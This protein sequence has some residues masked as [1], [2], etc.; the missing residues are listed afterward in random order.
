MAEV[1]KMKERIIYLRKN[2]LHLSQEEFGSYI[3]LKQGS[4]SA[5]EKGIN[6]VSEY[7]IKNICSQFSVNE[8]WLRH[9]IGDIFDIYSRN[10]KNFLSIYDNLSPVFQEFLEKV[11]KDLL[12]TQK[13]L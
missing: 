13:K 3:G 12:D 9:G 8:K 5:I 11:A 6:P 10:L 7:T 4:I 1:E 2:M